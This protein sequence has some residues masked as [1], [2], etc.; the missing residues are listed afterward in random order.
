MEAENFFEQNNQPFY[1]RLVRSNIPEEYDEEK[2]FYELVDNPDKIV[3]TEEL[4]SLEESYE[5]VD[6]VRLVEIGSELYEE[7]ERDYGI[8]APVEFI[9]GENENG[10]RVVYSIVDRVYGDNLETTEPTEGAIEEMEMLYVSISKY[11]LSKSQK[12][13]NHLADLNNAS[14]YMRGKIKGDEQPRIYLTDVDLYIN[15][16]LLALLHNIKWFLRHMSGIEKR[17][18]KKFEEARKNV[19][20]IIRDISLPTDLTEEEEDNAKRE[21]GEIKDMLSDDFSSLSGDETG[22]IS[23]P[24]II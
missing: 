12:E 1:K 11:Y 22:F 14:Q 2:R 4:A 20:T 9:I 21:I 7:L 10:E 5:G 8:L 3:R 16:G 6:P 23:S 18:G 24:I 15:S 17:A 13:E 19:D